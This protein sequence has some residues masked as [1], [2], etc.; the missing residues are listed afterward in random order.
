MGLCLVLNGTAMRLSAQLI[1]IPDRIIPTE[2]ME[3]I[4]FCI[5]LFFCLLASIILLYLL[6]RL[7]IGQKEQQDF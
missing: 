5:G 4:I 1:H 2:G 6:F 3:D 7:A